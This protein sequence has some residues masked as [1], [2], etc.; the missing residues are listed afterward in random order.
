MSGFYAQSGPA[1]KRFFGVFLRFIPFFFIADALPQEALYAIAGGEGPIGTSYISLVSSLGV[2]S[3]VSGA[4]PTG[5]GNIESVAINASGSAIVGGRENG[6]M[7]TPYI[8]L[9]SPSGIVTGVAGPAVPIGNGFVR[10]VAINNTGNGLLG[11]EHSGSSPYAALVT[12]SGFTTAL[13]GPAL[14]SGSGSIQ[15]VAINNSGYG[16]IAGRDQG[17]SVLY[18]AL[19][20]PSGATTALSGSPPP[21]NNGIFYTA[22]IN[23]SG[24]GV[25][26]GENDNGGSQPYAVL[27]N[28]NGVRTNLSGPAAPSGFG[29]VYSVAINDSGNGIV[30]GQDNGSTTPYAALFNAGGV[31]TPLSGPALPVGD[32]LILSVAINNSGTCVIGGQHNNNTD[33]YLALISPTGLTSAL[34]GDLPQNPAFIGSVAI[35]ESGVS[36]IGGP[37]DFGGGN[38][39]YLA[40]VSPLGVATSITGFLPSS[41]TYTLKVA[42]VNAL[43]AATP[44]TIG[45]AFDAPPISSLLLA[46]QAAANHAAVFQNWHSAKRKHFGRKR[47]RIEETALLSAADDVA[48]SRILEMRSKEPPSLQEE[49]EPLQAATSSFSI[50][51]IPFYAHIDQK[52]DDSIPSSTSQIPGAVAGFDYWATG[53]VAIG[54]ALAYA[55]DSIQASSQGRAKINQ[56]M[57]ALYASYCGDSFFINAALWGGYYHLDSTR[58]TLG[59]ISSTADTNGWLLSPHIE[60]CVS[61]Y[62]KS[63]WFVVE[64]YLMLDWVNNWQKGYT[65]KGASGLNLVVGDL[66]NS[67]LRSEIGFGFYQILSY[68]WGRLMFEERISYINKAPFHFNPTSVSFL[69]SPST[70]SIATGTN[71]VQ[72]QGGARFNIAF[73][74]ANPKYPYGL[75]GFVGEY[76]PTYQS[77]LANFELGKDF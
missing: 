13:S 14:F 72:S 64:P 15:S 24:S 44:P 1:G 7:Y 25:V 68:N 30:G 52:K 66:Y 60:V 57:A 55:F 61:D 65:E 28:S 48:M 75:I 6:P 26:G 49:T 42:I 21:T 63:T 22:A 4:L 62:D 8:G 2:A 12:P 31:R 29:S 3:P 45:P 23:G 10:S 46:S 41:P 77:N 39:P 56:G 59:F 40:L 5:T 33:A 67:L 17:G 9:I 18:A 11:G 71:Q 32:G 27:F 58:R 43:A 19:V 47:R 50:W 73:H 53:S 20:S 36:I 76:S 34:T 69:G 51:A 37:Q 54:G 74:P 16:V 38:D 70:F 35:A